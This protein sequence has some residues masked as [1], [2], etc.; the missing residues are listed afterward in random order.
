MKGVEVFL[1]D[2]H[3]LVLEAMRRLLTESR[4]DIDVEGEATTAE[5]ALELIEG[6]KVDVV[7]M[8]IRLPGMD[9]VEATKKLKERHPDMKV[10]ILS[11]FGQEYLKPSIEAGADGYLLKTSAPT[12]LVQGLM[13]VAH[14]QATIEASLTRHL[15]DWVAAI[16]PAATGPSLSPRQQEILRLVAD[17]LPS[18]EMGFQLFISQATL[19]REFK[20]IFNL[21]GVNDR[22]HAAAE[23]YRKHLI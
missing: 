1:V 18:K 20:N 16:P 3:P 2:D 22:A 15:M 4:E 13:Q 12:K 5:E 21:L 23:A 17:G 10:I 6:L 9:G 19:K 7:V 11:S 14:G 8:D